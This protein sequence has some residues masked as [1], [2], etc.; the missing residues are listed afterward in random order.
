VGNDVAAA[1]VVDLDL[2]TTPPP[3]VKKTAFNPHR[4]LYIGVAVNF[5]LLLLVAVLFAIS[6]LLWSTTPS[7]PLPRDPFVHRAFPFA[8][9]VTSVSLPPSFSF[10][11]ARLADLSI[12][13]VLADHAGGG[14]TCVHDKIVVAAAATTGV[15]SVPPL[16]EGATAC[17]LHVTLSV[18]GK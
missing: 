18:N 7:P 13:F 9:D 1:H 2:P 15:V 17:R 10:A 12:C 8:C 16:P 5:G 4:I 6:L 14:A 3:P 11:P